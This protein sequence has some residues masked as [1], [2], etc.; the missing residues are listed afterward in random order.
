MGGKKVVRDPRQ[1]VFN[2]QAHPVA[3]IREIALVLGDSVPAVERHAAARPDLI[4]LC[5]NYRDK[6]RA[7]EIKRLY[8]VILTEQKALDLLT[9]HDL[10]ELLG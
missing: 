3:D 2:E 10:H 9:V 4:E 8:G 6:L 7:K 1:L 5:N